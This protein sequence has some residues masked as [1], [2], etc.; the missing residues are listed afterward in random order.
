MAQELGQGKYRVV[1]KHRGR[2]LH[3][4]GEGMHVGGMWAKAFREGVLE[5]IRFQLRAK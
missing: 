1:W 3:G 5:E 4:C 2:H